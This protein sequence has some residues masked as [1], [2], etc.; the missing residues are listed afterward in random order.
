MNN[1]K[2]LLIEDNP[3]M[4]DNTAEILEL[5]NFDV[6]TAENGKEGVKMAHQLQ[7]DLI[8]CD[9][10]M[11]ELDGY[12][13]LHMLSKDDRTA[14]IPFIFLTAKAEKN[15]YR[16]GMTMGADDYL[17]KPYD[18]IELL[19]AVEMRI[20]KSERIKAEFSRTAEGL[21]KFIQEAR[22]FDSLSKLAEDKKIKY[23]RK[24]ETIYT[25]GS[26]PTGIFFL[27]KGKVKAYKANE[28]GKEYI[29]DLYKEGDFFGYVDLLQ[30]VPYQDSVVA[31]EDAEVAIIPKDDFFNLLQGSRDVSSK[32]IR[33]LSN[34]IKERED[35]LLQLAYNSVR[36]RVAEALV[37]LV[38]RYQNDHSKPFSMAITREDIASIVGTATETVIRTLS[39]FK[40][41]QLVDMK[42]SLITVLN[43]DRLAK[44]RN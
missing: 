5:A 37:M 36:K 11:P 13:V 8:I 10:M 28:F 21:D 2:I 3:E 41:E 35:R 31:L 19:S 16:K 39:D 22:S 43:Y 33:M 18:D 4:R 40:E 30:G 44:M 6:T 12:G 1:K 29:T 26:Y 23:I 42:G 15:D 38:N 24:K 7:P 17:T 32:F 34:E 20:K 14:G 25:E 27:Q 9:I